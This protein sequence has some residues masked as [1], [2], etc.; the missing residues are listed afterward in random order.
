MIIAL[1]ARDKVVLFNGDYNRPN[2]TTDSYKEWV[3]VNATLIS[4]ILNAMSNNMTSAV[5]YNKLKGLWEE[6]NGLKTSMR[7]GNFEEEKMMLFLMG[8]ND[9]F[10]PTNNR[11]ML[12]DPLPNLAREYGM[13]AN[14]EKQK[15]TQNLYQTYPKPQGSFIKEDRS[16]YKCEF[17]GKREHLKKD[18]FKLK[19]F[20]Y[21]WSGFNQ[22]MKQ[23]ANDV[24]EMS[25]PLKVLNEGKEGWQNMISSLIQQKIGKILKGK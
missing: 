3:K 24:Q 20:P 16:Q 21:W 15:R 13:I 4:W 5:F 14:V 8:L 11:I 7:Y 6:L 22:K 10:E 1:Q 23:K 12:Y 25:T 9:E 17:F 18:C 19:G 2:A